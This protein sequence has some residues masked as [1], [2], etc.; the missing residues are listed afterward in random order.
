MESSTDKISHEFDSWLGRLVGVC[1]EVVKQKEDKD[2]ILSDT[3]ANMVSDRLRKY[4]KCFSKSQEGDRIHLAEPFKRVYQTYKTKILHGDDVWLT[5]NPVSVQYGSSKTIKLHLSAIY[6]YAMEVDG[7]S[8]SSSLRDK[9]LLCIYN[10]IRSICCTTIGG[11]D[12]ISTDEEISVLDNKIGELDALATHSNATKPKESESDGTEAFGT[13][14]VKL[15]DMFGKLGLDMGDNM[16]SGKDMENAFEKLTGNKQMMGLLGG[17]V[18]SLKEGPPTKEKIGSMVES[19]VSAV[20][21]NAA[22]EILGNMEGHVSDLKLKN[23]IG[24]VAK[25]IEDSKNKSGGSNELDEDGYLSS[26]SEDEF[27]G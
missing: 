20:D 26:G 11:C 2:I 27:L 6:K 18:S 19:I 9:M 10:I 8:G 7:S 21:P 15:F 23:D 22:G 14:G 4:S 12:Y 24:V 1:V 13:M 16:P 5:H 3:M 17:M 25:A